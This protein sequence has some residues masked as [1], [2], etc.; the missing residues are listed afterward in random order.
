M[1]VPEVAI[2]LHRRSTTFFPFEVTSRILVTYACFD[3][4]VQDLPEGANSIVECDGTGVLNKAPCPIL[5]IVPGDLS[6]VL[7]PEFWPRFQ[8]GVR[9]LLA[10]VFG[11]GL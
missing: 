5:A 4:D 9:S 6:H 1:L 2:N 7:L 10:V 3:R 8:K 11:S